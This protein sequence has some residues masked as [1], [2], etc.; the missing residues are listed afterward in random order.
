[1]RADLPNLRQGRTFGQFEEVSDEDFHPSV[2]REKSSHPIWVDME[3]NGKA[4]IM[5]VDTR[6]AVSRN[7][8]YNEPEIILDAMLSQSNIML[9]MYTGEHIHVSVY[10]EVAAQVQYGEQ[11]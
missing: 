6:D 9:K 4:L 7:S 5:D 11:S 10:R 3:V 8:E 1:M 2:M